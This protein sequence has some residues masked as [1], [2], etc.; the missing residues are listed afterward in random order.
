MH[1]TD[2]CAW[3]H[4]ITLCSACSPFIRD[5]ADLY[6]NDELI[7]S[8]IDNFIDNEIDDDDAF[9]FR[10]ILQRGLFITPEDIEELESAEDS[11]S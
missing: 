5:L 9:S 6:R 2:I 4:A 8:E 1:M 7:R 10:N 11:F 3:E